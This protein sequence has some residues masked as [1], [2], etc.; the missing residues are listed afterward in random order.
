MDGESLLIAGGQDHKT[1][2][3][4]PEKAFIELEKYI[5]KYYPVSFVKYKWSSQYYIPVDGLPY[6]GQ[7]P[8]EPEGVYCAT[9]Y[10]GN[11]MMLGSF[12]AILLRDLILKKNSTY[13]KVFAPSRIKPVDGFTEF[14]KENADVAYH[15]IADRFGVKETDSLKRIAPG[16]GKVVEVKGQKIAAY[17]NENGEI[18]AL[19]PICSHAKCVVGWNTEEKSWDCPC[20][21]ARYDIDG[22]VITGP[23][24]KGLQRIEM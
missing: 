23:A 12:A 14:I 18:Y 20:H 22:K 16:T 19:N 7:M 6:I 15:F 5:R 4:D 13:Q 24:T 8:F 17:R 9:G 2:H 11:G 3:E 21:G 10:N 1:G